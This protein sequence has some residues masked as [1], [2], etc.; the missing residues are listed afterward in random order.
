MSLLH[1]SKKNYSILKIIDIIFNYITNINTNILNINENKIIA[2]NIIKLADLEFNISSE[3]DTNITIGAIIS[4][5]WE[6]KHF[7]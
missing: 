5:I 6:I 3:Y 2:K 1:R 4:I 7:I